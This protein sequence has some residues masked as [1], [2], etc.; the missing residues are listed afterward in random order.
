MVADYFGP[1][2]LKTTRLGWQAEVD[3]N[4]RTGPSRAAWVVLCTLL[5]CGAVASGCGGKSSA[6]STIDSADV[7][8][9]TSS[10]T[11]G[12]AVSGGKTATASGAATGGTTMVA[13]GAATSGT[14][15]VAGGAATGG[16]TMVA[17]GAATGG[18]TMVAGGAR[19]TA[20]GA[21]PTAGRAATGLGGG[22]TAAAGMPSGGQVGSGGGAAGA[23]NAAV[24]GFDKIDVLLVLDNS[25][26]MGDKQAVLAAALPQ[27]LRRL[28]NP[29]C[30]D[31]SGAA[32]SQ[33]PADPNAA[34]PAGLQRDFVPV[35]DIHVG[36]VTS[37]LGDFGGDTCPEDGPQYLPQNDHAWL[38]GALPRTAATLNGMPFLSWT[39]ADAQAYATQIDAKG[40]EF[41]SLVTAATELGCG[42]EMPL[43]AWY[44]FLVDP[45]PPIDV[46]MTNS[47]ANQR[48]P[49]DNTILD[50]RKA[51]LRPDSLVAVLV[52]SD[53]NDCSMRDDTYAWVAMTASGGFRMWR[54]ST[55]CATNPNDPCCYTC[56]L[57]D[58]KLGVSQAC[59]DQ[60]PTCRQGDP[61]GKLSAPA[62]DINL[63]CRQM[64]RRFGYDFL[65]PPS[66][67]VNALT[68]S[69][70]CPDQSYGDLDCN[71]TEAKKKGASCVPGTAVKNP[72]YLNLNPSAA[73]TGS[74]RTGPDSV[75]LVGIVGVPWQDLARDP[76]DSAVL[77]FKTASNLDWNLFAP[78]VDEDYSTAALG[79]PLMVESTQPRSGQHPITGQDI[80]PPAA[81]RG[82]N[83]INGHEWN[84]ADKDLQF[85]CI[86]SLEFE[87]TPGKTAAR[88]CDLAS[89]CGTNDGSDSYKICS[90]KFDGCSCTL[91]NSTPKASLDPTVSLSPLCQNAQNQ[92]GNTQ[93]FAKAYPGLRELQVL[94]GF[95]DATN[96]DNAIVGSICPKDL[97]FGNRASAGYGY[98]PAIKSLVDGLKGKLV[99]N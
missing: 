86:F 62:D 71:C 72:L 24:S 63:R 81:S 52:L 2:T 82:A 85:A 7:G 89:E 57:A 42:F 26:S 17:G 4:T 35:K 61:S 78:K 45:K 54:G 43:E 15:M 23:S 97:D 46:T 53:E 83:R 75:F 73:S 90:R 14:T 22:T 13:G 10:T 91:S 55:A 6:P 38:L 20:G 76:S 48:G 59:L 41:R 44:R 16:T 9:S 51:F 67:Y 32:A 39:P 70:I 19:T 36:V 64:K 5:H 88:V 56:M 27:L 96:S 93:Y 33:T 79:D 1:D 69:D 74:A 11:L 34:C 92:Y 84:T 49:V 77:E 30:V 31:P 60:D 8:G 47:S 65:F 87:L 29:D 95:H 18:T 68:K 37:A 21:G 40:V 12:G 25:L 58:A 80:A 94:R 98:N 66:R 99:G 3:I 28:T 50:L